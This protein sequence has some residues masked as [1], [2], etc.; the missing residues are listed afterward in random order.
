MTRF[1]DPFSYGRMIGQS[2]YLVRNEAHEILGVVEKE[3][4]PGR[5]RG[6]S[7]IYW[8]A[9]TRAGT[10]LGLAGGRRDAAWRLDARRHEKAA[11]K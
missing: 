10:D 3:I 1:R 5:Y 8:R 2:R 7:R 4:H 6:T 11:A 9:T